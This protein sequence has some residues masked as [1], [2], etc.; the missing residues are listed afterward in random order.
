MNSRMEAMQ[1]AKCLGDGSGG[2]S[3]P[4]VGLTLL[5]PARTSALSPTQKLSKPHY[6]GG[7]MEVSL[8]N[9]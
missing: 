6:L 2:P 3:M 1:G 8:H 7:F 5:P 9:I 4:S